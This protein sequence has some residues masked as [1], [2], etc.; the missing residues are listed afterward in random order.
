MCNIDTSKVQGALVEFLAIWIMPM[1][2]ALCRM[3]Q[4]DQNEVYTTDWKLTRV[5]AA[6]VEWLFDSFEH[7]FIVVWQVIWFV[8]YLICLILKIRSW[9]LVQS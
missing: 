6:S 7:V 8:N 2:S 5:C 9:Q 4:L 1:P 3:D